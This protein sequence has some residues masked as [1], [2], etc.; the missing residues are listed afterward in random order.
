MKKIILMLLCIATIPFFFSGCSA[1]G[2]DVSF[3][4]DDFAQQKSRTAEVTVSQ[5][6]TITVTL[7][8]NA[9]TG[10]NWDES[11][12]IADTTVLEQ[13]GHRFISPEKSMAGAAGQEEWTFKALGPGTT[14]AY[15]EYSRPWE[16]GE[17][18]VWT[19]TL[20]VKV[21]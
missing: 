7:C 18:G 2:A 5:G 11:V 12:N 14:T 8:S 15:M 17:K 1:S 21:K 10:F 16:G 6:E 20:T 19:F 13:T 3:S 9:T 4:C